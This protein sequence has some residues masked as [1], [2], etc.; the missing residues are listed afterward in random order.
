MS[1]LNDIRRF[2][3]RH[4]IREGFLKSKI[5]LT[6]TILKSRMFMDHLSQSTQL[7]N[8]TNDTLCFP[9]EMQVQMKEEDQMLN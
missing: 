2:T 1:R 5:I 6:L 9:T 3:C 8:L 4:S 7:I